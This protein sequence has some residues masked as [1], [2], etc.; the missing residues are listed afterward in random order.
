MAE[1][2]KNETAFADTLWLLEQWARWSRIN[3]GPALKLPSVTPYRRL[4]GSTLPSPVIS[5]D[6]AMQIDSVV[7]RLVQRD[8]ETG[9]AIILYYCS[10]GN[11]SDVAR[12]LG[13]PRRKIDILIK[14]GTSWLDG[15]LNSR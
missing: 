12:R 9:K 5:D 6:A 10:S 14:A 1:V 3:P 4:L 13:Q 15:A 11:I 7:A 8:S 2:V